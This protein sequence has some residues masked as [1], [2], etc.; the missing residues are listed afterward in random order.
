MGSPLV[1]STLPYGCL[2]QRTSLVHYSQTN[3]FQSQP[4]HSSHPLRR[5]LPVLRRFT[6][7]RLDTIWRP[8]GRWL[9]WKTHHPGNRT[10][11]GIL[12]SCWRRNHLNW[13]IKGPQTSPK[14]S[15]PSRHL[16]LKYFWV[17]SVPTA[18]LWSKGHSQTLGSNKVLTN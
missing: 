11:P 16:L 7:Q 4:F 9:L 8:P 12:A 3:P 6:P 15:R 17:A 14:F 5:Q 13:S 1:P 18:T 2:H 10:G